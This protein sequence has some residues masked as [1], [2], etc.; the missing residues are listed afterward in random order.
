MVDRPRFQLASIHA[1]LVRDARRDKTMQG[2]GSFGF[3][4]TRIS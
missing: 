3:Q 1:H 4:S 2:S